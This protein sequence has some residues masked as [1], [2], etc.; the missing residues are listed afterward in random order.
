M[1][2]LIST[3]P[4]P[5]CL[6]LGN[7]G[8]SRSLAEFIASIPKYERSSIETAR[9]AIAALLMNGALEPLSARTG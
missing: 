9:L 1:R 4:D 5:R 2:P 3:T 6:R 8:S 7:P